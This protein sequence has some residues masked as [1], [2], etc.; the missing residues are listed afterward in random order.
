MPSYWVLQ[1]QHTHA[2]NLNTLKERTTKKKWNKQNE[3]KRRNKTPSTSQNGHVCWMQTSRRTV[4]CEEHTHGWI[5]KAQHTHASKQVPGTVVVRTKSEIQRRCQTSVGKCCADP[6]QNRYTHKI[7]QKNKRKRTPNVNN[8][9]E[10]LSR[11]ILFCS[12]RENLPACFLQYT[13]CLVR[14]TT[15]CTLT[16]F[17]DRHSKKN[18]SF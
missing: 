4:Q 9:T 7:R 1:A 18:V 11:S 16:C 14:D 6:R 13:W 17:V 8:K 5:R 3:G 10:C 2:S 15:I 12:D